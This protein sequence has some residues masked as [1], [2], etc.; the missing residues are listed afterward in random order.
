ML[1][2]LLVRRSWVLRDTQSSSHYT[3]QSLRVQ[4]RLLEPWV[5]V[6]ISG[7]F[8]SIAIFVRLV[9]IPAVS[10]QIFVIRRR[11]ALIISTIS[12]RNVVGCLT[13]RFQ[14]VLGVKGTFDLSVEVCKYF[15]SERRDRIHTL[16]LTKPGEPPVT[17]CDIYDV[18]VLDT[19]LGC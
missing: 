18:S 11:Q 3:L 2:S 5:H 13:Y 12:E 8:G 4:V 14:S 9:R 16:L 15:F 19:G 17:C 6:L 7:R 1:T 10:S